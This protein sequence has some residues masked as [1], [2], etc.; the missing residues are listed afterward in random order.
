MHIE[1]DEAKRA[2]MLH[3]RGLYFADA[4]RVLDGPTLEQLDSRADY[5]EPRTIGIG[6]LD[7]QVVVP[8]WTPPPRQG[9]PHHLHEVRP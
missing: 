6:M 9:S 7:G 4:A 3:E 8:V 2:T 5:G 1:Y